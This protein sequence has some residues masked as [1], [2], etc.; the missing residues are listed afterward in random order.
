[1][2]GSAPF[3]GVGVAL[4]TLFDEEGE[5]DAPATADH[6]ARLVDAGVMRSWSP[7]APVRPPRS[8]TRSGAT[9]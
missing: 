4:V 3:T 9:C 5:I 2:A 7:G 6:A 8:T 1:M